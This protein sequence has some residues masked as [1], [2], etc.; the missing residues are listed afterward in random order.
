MKEMAD[1]NK[2]DKDS[3]KDIDKYF[4]GKIKNE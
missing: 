2:T 1:N 4:G 3:V